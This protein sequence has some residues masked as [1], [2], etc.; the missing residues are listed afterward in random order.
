MH[1]TCRT[2]TYIQYNTLVVC[3]PNTPDASSP[4]PLPLNTTTTTQHHYSPHPSQMMHVCVPISHQQ[5]VSTRAAYGVPRW[6]GKK[7]AKRGK[8]C[9][10]ALGLWSAIANMWPRHWCRHY[11]CVGPV[12]VVVV[13]CVCVGVGVGVCRCGGMLR[14]VLVHCRYQ[15]V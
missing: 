2:K 10:W 11:R 8:C 7:V 12:L 1:A 13:V 5:Q 9:P 14:C 15:L 4:P 6:Q 3:P